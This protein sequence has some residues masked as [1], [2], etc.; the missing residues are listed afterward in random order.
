MTEQPDGGLALRV[1]DANERTVGVGLLIGPQEV[2]TC[3]HV[4]NI[5]LGRD[6][7]AQDRPAVEVTVQFT[8][9]DRPPLRAEVRCWLPPPR[10]GAIGDDIAG[11]VLTST[12]LPTG[13]IPALLA[14]NPPAQGR[15]VDV[16]GYPGDSEYEDV[17]GAAC[18]V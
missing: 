10:A 17:G 11:L 14:V 12:E 6:R 15:V 8:V 3:A 5:A 13:A 2:L 4:V 16:F 1:L 18:R 9:G 7:A